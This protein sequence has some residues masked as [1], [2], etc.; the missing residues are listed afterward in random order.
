MQ[1]RL[2]SLILCCQ[3]VVNKLAG[4]WWYD[5]IIHIL[6]AIWCLRCPRCSLQVTH[7]WGELFVTLKLVNSFFL[8][9][10]DKI[11]FRWVWVYTHVM[12]LG[13]SIIRSRVGVL[14]V[15]WFVFWSSFCKR[16]GNHLCM[17]GFLEIK[18]KTTQLSFAPY[19]FCFFWV[20]LTLILNIS[21]FS[22]T[23]DSLTRMLISNWL[24]NL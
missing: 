22:N 2:S 8:S 20:C 11:T 18:S 10:L 1:S 9:S 3:Y 14:I 19:P 12:Q 23:R 16:Q 24:T 15:F 21:L 4:W 17:D 13:F 7:S 5:A 6:I